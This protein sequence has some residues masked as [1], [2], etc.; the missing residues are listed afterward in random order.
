MNFNTYK[1]KVLQVGSSNTKIKHQ[2]NGVQLSSVENEKDLGIF[3][4]SDVKPG[5]H[6]TE[7]VKSA[8][9][10]VGFV[11]R[12]FEFRSEKSI[13]TLYNSLLCPNLEYCV[14]FLSPYYKT[15]VER[16]GK[17]QHSLTEIIPR[18]RNISCEERI[19]ELN[20]SV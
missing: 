5:F 4:T 1:C 20:N 8:N 10:L 15:D 9:I 3:I 16:I 14:Q 12:A 6:C 19:E 11:G 2:M 17:I 13:L 7:V 18:L